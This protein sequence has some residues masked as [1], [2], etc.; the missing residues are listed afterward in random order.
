MHANRWPGRSVPLRLASG[1]DG[2]TRTRARHPGAD[3]KPA[4]AS[5]SEIEAFLRSRSSRR[6]PGILVIAYHHAP[7]RS[8]RVA[9]ALSPICLRGKPANGKPSPRQ[10]RSACAPRFRSP[11]Y[12]LAGCR[13]GSTVAGR[14][15]EHGRFGLDLVVAIPH[16]TPRCRPRSTRSRK[17]S[18]GCPYGE[19]RA[20]TDLR[21][22]KSQYQ[23]ISQTLQV[24]VDLT[25]N[26]TR[27]SQTSKPLMKLGF[28]DGT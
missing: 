2:G 18:V 13:C 10:V 17:S 9:L 4:L 25:C 15:I 20:S 1:A 28:S 22:E 19:F 11:S 8:D 23:A 16:E 27:S 6:S 24:S 14:A 7:P 5:Y 21:A 3:F 26:P 12:Q